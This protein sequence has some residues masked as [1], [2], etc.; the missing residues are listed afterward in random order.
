VTHLG[1]ALRAAREAA[2]PTAAELA[3]RQARRDAH[4]GGRTPATGISLE[5]LAER[6][7]RLLD[8]RGVTTRVHR[9]GLSKI[10]RTGPGAVKVLELVAEALGLDVSLTPRKG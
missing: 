4:A 1:H 2:Q 10:E 8:A 7:N 6:C 5:E 3:A 9:T